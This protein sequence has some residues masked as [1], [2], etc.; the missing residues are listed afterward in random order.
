MSTKKRKGRRKY[1]PHVPHLVRQRGKNRYWTGWLEGKEFNLH[2]ADAQEAQRRL[3]ALAGERSRAEDD[4]ETNQK[5]PL[6]ELAARYIEHI[7]PP[8]NTPKT[9][10]TYANRILTFVTRAETLGVHQASEVSFKFMS[11]FVR[12]RAKSGVSGTTINRDVAPVKRMFDFGKRE[13]LLASNPFNHPDFKELRMREARP[14]PNSVTLSLE[15]VD[16]FIS[17]AHEM[18][19]LGYAALFEVTAGSAIRVDEA[20]HL[21]HADLD[22]TGG[23]LGVTPKKN[24]T[25]KNYRYRTIPVSKATLAAAAKFIANRHEVRLDD[26]ATWTAIKTVCEAMGVKPFTMHDLRRFWGSAMH[27]NGASLKQVSVLL[28][29]S[30]VAVTERYLRVLDG[31]VVAHAFLPR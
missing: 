27:A 18:L 1:A 21:D 4:G 31:Q 8:R 5:T 14:R 22:T 29:H 20:R 19:H 6:T 23:Y 30:G 11:D 28:G 26:K 15:L 25:T 7:Q 10:K 12:E 9:S 24:W 16:R 13:G 2:T 17:R 3:D